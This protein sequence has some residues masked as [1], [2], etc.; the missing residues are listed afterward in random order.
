MRGA[1]LVLVALL[2]LPVAAL[3]HPGGLDAKG[4]HRNRKTGEYHC[5]RC[6]CGCETQPTPATA[7]P[8]KPNPSS[9]G[10]VSPLV[11]APGTVSSSSTSATTEASDPQAAAVCVTKSGAKYHRPTCRSARTCTRTMTP[12]EAKAAGYT[13]CSVCAPP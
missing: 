11:S 7:P 5:H 3:G 4:G 1:A 6:P 10:T 9:A 13:P 8:T 2:A 12:A